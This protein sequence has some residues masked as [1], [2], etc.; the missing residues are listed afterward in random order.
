MS[1]A[2]PPSPKLSPVDKGNAASLPQPPPLVLDETVNAR[3][4]AQELQEAL[5]K[6]FQSWPSSVSE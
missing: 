6:A 3:L 4:R 5:H 1:A 2:P